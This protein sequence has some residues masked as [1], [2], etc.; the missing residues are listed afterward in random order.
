M[1]IIETIFKKE[2]FLVIKRE[3]KINVSLRSLSDSKI[4][5]IQQAKLFGCLNYL[6]ISGSNIRYFTMLWWL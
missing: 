3:G 4:T 6:F 2:L 5:M 1:K